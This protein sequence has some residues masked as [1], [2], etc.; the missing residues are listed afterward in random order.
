MY[1]IRRVA[2]VQFTGLAQLVADSVFYKGIQNIRS[3]R[4]DKSGNTTFTIYELILTLCTQC[5][6]SVKRIPLD[7][8]VPLLN[9]LASVQTLVYLKKI[10]K[11]VMIINLESDNY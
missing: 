8:L 9:P 1:N 5:N 6:F 2:G 10:I 7:P 4:T 11:Y 3:I